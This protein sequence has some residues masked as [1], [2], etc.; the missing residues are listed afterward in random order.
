MVPRLGVLALFAWLASAVALADSAIDAFE[1]ADEQAERRYQSLVAE[2]RCPK[3]LN[4][5]LAG[6]DAPI[7]RD[8][9]NEVYRQVSDGATDA[10]IR[11]YLQSRYG[12]FVLYDPPMRLD[13]LLLWAA[14]LLLLGVAAFVLMRIARR[15]DG[16]GEALSPDERQRLEALVGKY[17]EKNA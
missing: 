11:D 1:F 6:S 12:D 17:G 9:R 13:T 15:S 14:P 5:N 10:E 3:C 4:T 8:L 16:P 2:F 7:A